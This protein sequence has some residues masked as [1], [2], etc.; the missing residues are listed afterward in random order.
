MALASGSPSMFASGQPSPPRSVLARRLRPSAAHGLRSGTILPQADL[1]I[2]VF[3]DRRHGFAL[4]FRLAGGGQ[5]YP[6][7]SSD[8]GQ[9]WRIAGP[10]LHI[11]AAQGAIAVNEPGVQGSRFYY[12]WDD[13]YNTVIDVTTD[14][15]RHWWQTFLPGAVLSVTSEP[16]TG[17][18]L[19]ALVEG[20]TT[21]PSGHGASLWDYRTSDGRRWRYLGSQNAVS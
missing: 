14:A 1:G 13:G 15:G 6:V 5:T 8:G 16:G 17:G 3:A 9:T 18:G 21:D 7:A 10:V 20:P 11:N 2:R 4:A 12:A 19:A